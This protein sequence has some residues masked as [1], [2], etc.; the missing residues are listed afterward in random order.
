VDI[1]TTGL[2]PYASITTAALYDGTRLRTYVQGQNLDQFAHDIAAYAVVVTFNGKSFD[3]PILERS[4]PVTMPRAHIDLLHVLRGLGLK[5]GL[6]NV[7]KALGLQ[8]PGM[9]E[10]DGSTAVLL[11]N[12]Y[13]H[14]QNPK[15]LE[16]L[17]A[18]NSYDVIN[19]HTLVV[20]AHNANVKRTPFGPRHQLP[21]P[22]APAVPFAHD[23]DLIAR[24][25][26]GR[27][28]MLPRDRY[29]RW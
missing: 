28:A 26:F 15:A 7:E 24:L 11:W 16:T 18:Y 14:R 27:D 17:L 22:V 19:L 3:V 13:R 25:S 12:E 20:H 9:A 4:L 8:R 2:G 29:R 5:G 21:T 6:K 23:P 1:E 10:V